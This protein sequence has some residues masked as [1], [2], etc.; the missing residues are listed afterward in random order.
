MHKKFRLE[1]LVC[2]KVIHCAEYINVLFGL[3]LTEYIEGTRELQNS[4]YLGENCYCRPWS[5]TEVISRVIDT[6]G[7]GAGIQ[8]DTD[9]RNII[10]VRHLLQDIYLNTKTSLKKPFFPS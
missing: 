8:I 3:I 9:L 5:S 4:L 2:T 1:T 6:D 7:Y 10:G